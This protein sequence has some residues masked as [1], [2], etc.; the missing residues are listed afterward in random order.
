[1]YVILHL[2]QRGGAWAWRGPAQSPHRCTKYNS[3]YTP[4]INHMYVVN[5]L[6]DH[7]VCRWQETH[8]YLILSYLIL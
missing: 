3:R 7:C 6:S 5:C 4:P 1:M 2:V 8:S